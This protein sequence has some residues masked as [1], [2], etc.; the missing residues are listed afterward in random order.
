M[1][2]LVYCFCEVPVG[3][4]EKTEKGYAYTSNIA[5]EQKLRKRSLVFSSKYNLWGSF[6]REL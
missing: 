6:K 5:N 3:V 4:Y 2:K 1:K